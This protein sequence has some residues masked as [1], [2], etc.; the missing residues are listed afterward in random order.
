MHKENEHAKVNTVNQ[1][2]CMVFEAYCN[3]M[4]FNKVKLIGV[5]MLFFL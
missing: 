2:I 5:T 3:F 1:V 4:Q